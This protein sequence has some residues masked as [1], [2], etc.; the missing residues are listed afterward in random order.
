MSDWKFGSS[1][2][3]KKASAEAWGTDAANPGVNIDLDVDATDPAIANSGQPQSSGGDYRSTAIG[4]SHTLFSGVSNFVS[5]QSSVSGIMTSFTAGFTAHGKAE[6][7]GNQSL[8][9]EAKK[10]GEVTG[11]IRLRARVV[12]PSSPSSYPNAIVEASAGSTNISAIFNGTRWSISGTL[13]VNDQGTQIQE[14]LDPGWGELNKTYYC[15]EMVTKNQDWEIEA[16]SEIGF[17]N[18]S[19]GGSMVE[20]DLECGALVDMADTIIP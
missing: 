9:S 8:Q 3:T 14:S 15:D 2:I 7:E 1:S 10:A 13:F 6:A 4:L 19:S 17:F 16:S 20:H 12:S 18:V 5:S 11:I